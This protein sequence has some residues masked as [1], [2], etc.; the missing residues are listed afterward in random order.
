MIRVMVAGQNRTAYVAAGSLSID[1]S[2]GSK[3]R[4]SVDFVI[5]DNS[6]APSPG[7]DVDIWDDEPSPPA[8]LLD[9]VIDDITSR[10]LTLAAGVRHVVSIAADQSILDKRVV[11]RI[12]NPI[13]SGS[14]L[15]A[16][17]RLH[18]DYLAGS[19]ITFDRA[20]SED[21]TVGMIVLPGITLRE[22]FDK[23]GEASGTMWYID[24]ANV[25]RFAKQ[26]SQFA[27]PPVNPLTGDH[28]FIGA[29]RRSNFTRL[30]NRIYAKSANYGQ[31]TSWT[32]TR[33]GDGS[34]RNFQT[35]YQVM[36]E[37]VVTINGSPAGVIESAFAIPPIP[38]WVDFIW[39]RGFAA[40]LHNP[41]K[42]PLGPTDEIK[43]TYDTPVP[44]LAVAEDPASIAAYGLWEAVVEY[45]EARSQKALEDYAASVLASRAT[46]GAELACDTD[47]GHWRPGMRVQVQLP[48]L[49]ING[50]YVV[51]SCS[52]RERADSREF[53]YSLNLSASHEQ[54]MSAGADPAAY[55]EKLLARDAGGFH[56]TPA[57][58]REVI[59]FVLAG[60]IEGIA[61][62]GL[63]IGAKPPRKVVKIGGILREVSLYF[64]TAPTSIVD[65]DV[66]LNTASVF[67]NS[68]A[69]PKLQA[70]QNGPVRVTGGFVENPL[71]IVPGDLL[72]VTVMQASAAAKDGAVDIVL[73]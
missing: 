70:G 1:L 16:V 21:A 13:V 52:A 28:I 24:Q 73:G 72:S 22:A 41:D 53:V 5:T 63:T 8:L 2:P 44:Y 34:N 47:T 58:N 61:N 40:L 12:V 17:E 37:P 7:Q 45:N 38:S 31:T 30:A 56:A 68:G 64:R 36:S 3:P 25:L 19:G 65:V 6:W 60:T 23:L 54:E 35:S 33:Y 62:P 9:G 15:D 66:I 67:A 4:G 39:M 55:L 50:H 27:P 11:N 20:G 51:Q 57:S 69:R 10:W 18:G 46:P 14:L 59:T 42:P 29:E 48:Q 49:G 32:D 26:P 43:I 71:V